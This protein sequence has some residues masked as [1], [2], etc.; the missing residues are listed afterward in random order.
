MLGGG[1][2]L[3]VGGRLHEPLGYING[4]GSF[5][6]LALWICL[7]A[8]ESRAQPLVAGLGMAG[9]TLFVG[10]AVLSQSRGVGLALL[11]SA[12]VAL[13]VLPGRVRRFGAI[14]LLA[15]FVAVGWT[16]LTGVFDARAAAGAEDAAR[17]AALL[18]LFGALALGVAWGVACA[19]VA[20]TRPGPGAVRLNRACAAA[21]VGLIVLGLAAAAVKA[22]PLRSQVRTQW[23]AFT[24]LDPAGQPSATAART[25]LVSGGGNRYEYWRVGVDSWRA[26]PL[27]GNGAGSFVST[28]YRKRRITEE[29]RQPHSLAI[30]VAG[31]TGVLG[32]AALAV[33]F[34]GVGL[35]AARRRRDVHVSP[36]ARGLVVAAVGMFSTWAIHTQVDWMHL[37]PG[38]TGIGLA[39]GAW[40][41]AT[42]GDGSG[43]VSWPVR[44]V[45]LALV[46]AA[47]VLVVR[48]GIADHERDMARD[49]LAKNPAATLRDARHSLDFDPTAVESHY[50]EAAALARF[51]AAG[52]ADAALHK[53]AR[54]EPD[55]FVTWTLIGD[56]ATRRGRRA[57]A[58]GAYRRASTLNPLDTGLRASVRRSAR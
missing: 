3:F 18:L 29:I 58:L 22:G 48:Q 35:G 51:G 27:A 15:A 12:L 17:N 34:V 49:D 14:V 9:A 36:L 8:A 55:N 37:L 56:L 57:E 21:A 40:L 24:H 44:G 39:G 31:G 4:E 23:H 54:E 43:N 42:R 11:G 5:F 1:G 13:A 46:F 41:A 33:A 47:T 45:L 30:E 6:L 20:S 10:L 16:T 26:A 2:D 32:L 52:P 25:R 19:A 53:A 38:V 50:L 7:G 28:W